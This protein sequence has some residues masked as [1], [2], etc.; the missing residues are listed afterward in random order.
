MQTIHKSGVVRENFI[1]LV[2]TGWVLSFLYE[3]HE[4][5]TRSLWPLCRLHSIQS[6]KKVNRFKYMCNI[7]RIVYSSDTVFV[8]ARKLPRGWA[9]RSH[10]PWEYLEHIWTLP[11]SMKSDIMMFPEYQQALRICIFKC[12]YISL[13]I[14]IFIYK[15]THAHIYIYIYIHMYMYIYIYIYIYLYIYIY[16]YILTI[17]G[18]G[19]PYW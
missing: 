9:N 14:Y 17:N 1:R 5:I 13:Y 15:C 2:N 16:I 18:L 8:K 6:Q 10:T 7:N 4:A 12:I 19:D 11:S 3:K